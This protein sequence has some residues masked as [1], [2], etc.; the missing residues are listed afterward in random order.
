MEAAT[1]ALVAA[2]MAMAE[3]VAELTAC[4]LEAAVQ[5]VE[6]ALQVYDEAQEALV[7]VEDDLDRYQSV[8]KKMEEM[9]AERQLAAGVVAMD[10]AV[11]A[12][13]EQVAAMVPTEEQAAT[14][15]QAEEQTTAIYGESRGAGSRC[16]H[17][18]RGS[19]RGGSRGYKGSS[20]GGSNESR[21]SR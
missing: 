12:E 4:G 20:E 9:V 16:G 14:M 21:G 8:D 6:A 2:K 10:E 13:K 11:G 7:Q 15:V 18:C 3:E 1:D 5:E 17:R 19:N